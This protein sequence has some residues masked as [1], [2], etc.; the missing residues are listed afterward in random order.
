VE[1]TC[2]TMLAESR[3]FGTLLPWLEREVLLRHCR[4]GHGFDEIAAT[5]GLS[6]FET[7]RLHDGASRRL[8]LAVARLLR[9]LEIE[10][11]TADRATLLQQIYDAEAATA[12][13]SR[14]AKPTAV[15]QF[16]AR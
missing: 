15:E 3:G 2:S 11:L 5:F 14:G 4:E 1:R 13:A 6:A 9:D 16:S 7:R 12:G 8:D 10:R